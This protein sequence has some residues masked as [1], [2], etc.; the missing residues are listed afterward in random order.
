MIIKKKN[1]AAK[2]LGVGKDRIKFVRL[3]L[4]EIKEAI[5]KQDM[6]DLLESG[7]I[8]LKPV[9]GRRTNV[10]RKN[11]RGTGKVRKKVNKRKQ[12]YVKITRK[13]REYIK[14]LKRRGSLTPDEVKQLRIQIRNKNF[15]SKSNFKMHIEGM[16]K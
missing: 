6:R 9:K 8:I 2:A 3:R 4:D 14:D 5:T 1:L 7:A 13:L 11:K 10:K 16:K 12:N 15:K